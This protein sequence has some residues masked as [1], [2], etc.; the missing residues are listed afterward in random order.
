[1]VW[2]VWKAVFCLTIVYVSLYRFPNTISIAFLQQML[3][4]LRNYSRIQLRNPM[5]GR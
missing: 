5:I 3:T 1:M 2:G 4:V